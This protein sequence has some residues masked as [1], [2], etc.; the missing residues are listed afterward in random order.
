L[1]DEGIVS[2]DWEE[3]ELTANWRHFLVRPDTYLRHLLEDEEEH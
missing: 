1:S 2:R 3:L